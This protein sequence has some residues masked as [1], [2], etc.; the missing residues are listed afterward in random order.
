ME[1]EC[2]KNREISNRK[3]IDQELSIFLFK[4]DMDLF[5]ISEPLIPYIME[6]SFGRIDM[7]EIIVI[8]IPP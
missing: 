3:S 1:V 8:R 5:S 6:V 4:I 7:K 2:V